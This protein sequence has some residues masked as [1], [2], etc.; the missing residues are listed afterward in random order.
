MVA[1]KKSFPNLFLPRC[2]L[3]LLELILLL[4]KLLLR[5]LLRSLE[6]L[7]L[8]LY[9]SWTTPGRWGITR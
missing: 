6:L 1:S 2:L 3:Q 5:L 7:T 8:L 4:L 9:W